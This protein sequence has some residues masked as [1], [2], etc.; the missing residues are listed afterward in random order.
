[1]DEPGG[2]GKGEPGP[3]DHQDRQQL[4]DD[5][6]RA[7]NDP[8]YLPTLLVKDFNIQ[9]NAAAA[10][11]PFAV[12]KNEL[13]VPD[14]Y[15]NH[16][17]AIGGCDLSATTDLTCAT[18]LIRRP[19]DPHFYVLQQ[20]F[21]PKARVEQI[22]TRGEKEAPYT[23][24]AEQKWLTTL[25]ESATV[26]YNAVTA[27]FVKNG[28]RAGHQAAVEMLRRGPVRL[29]GA[30]DDGNRFEMEK[31]RQGP[32]TWTYPMKRMEGPVRD[33]LMVYQ[34]KP[35]SCGGAC[36]TRRPEPAINAESTASNRKNHVEQ[37]NRRNGQPAERHGGLLQPRRRIFCNI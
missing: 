18:L 14:E 31:I 23:L 8:S 29:L 11:L 15:L 24:W 9:E 34:N 4:A 27:W 21:L 16:T 25:C 26:D 13:V 2:V 6:E 32:V 12:L 30:A 5:V 10:W 36:R 3:G 33:H 17:Y 1:M 22:Q 28:P 20:Y 7:K 37:T 35:G 19:K